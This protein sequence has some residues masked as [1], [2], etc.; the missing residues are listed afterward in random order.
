MGAFLQFAVVLVISDF[1]SSLPEK[2]TIL[3]V[4]DGLKEEYVSKTL[5][6][7]VNGL[8]ETG[9]SIKGVTPIFPALKYPNIASLLTGVYAEN[10]NVL[11]SVVFDKTADANLYRNESGFWN[12]T[13]EIGTIWVSFALA[14][15]H[16]VSFEIVDLGLDSGPDSA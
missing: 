14:I 10:H 5:T 12:S 11:D 9:V 3:V 15:A 8:L 16:T 4:A 2:L 6:P 1:V 7:N 13:R